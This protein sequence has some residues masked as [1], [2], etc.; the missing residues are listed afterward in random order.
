MKLA[1]HSSVDFQG[2]KSDVPGRLQVQ[3]PRLLLFGVPSE[4][5]LQTPCALQ[6]HHVAAEGVFSQASWQTDA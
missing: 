1:E 3:L 4:R 5:L 2:H 6:F